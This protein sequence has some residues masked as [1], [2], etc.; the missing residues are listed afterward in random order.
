[1]LYL[2]Q[3]PRVRTYRDLV[4]NLNVLDLMCMDSESEPNFSWISKLVPQAS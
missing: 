2:E 4:S 3:D 1:M